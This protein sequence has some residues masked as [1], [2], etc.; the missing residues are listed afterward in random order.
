MGDFGVFL[1][2][3]RNSICI[4]HNERRGDP[5][6]GP[7]LLRRGHWVLHMW[8]ST[9]RSR[10]A[11]LALGGLQRQR[12]VWPHVHPWVCGLQWEG[13]RPALPD[14]PAQQRGRQSGEGPS[15]SSLL[16]EGLQVLTV[17]VSPCRPWLQ[18]CVRSASA[19]ACRALV[20]CGPAGCAC[21]ASARWETSSRTASMAL[22]ESFTPT[23]GATGP[24]TKPT[25]DTWSPKTRLTSPPHPWIW[26]ISRNH[27]ISAPT[28]E[29]LE[30]WEHLEGCATAPLQA[31]MDASCSAADAGLRRG[32]R[33]W[34]S[35][36]T[37][38][39][40]GAVTSAAWTAPAPERYT[41][42]YDDSRDV[43][44]FMRDAVARRT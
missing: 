5:R 38:P 1:R 36:A 2:L 18:R 30:L 20:P 21:P 9:Q 29:K 8:L 39:S 37:A 34:P 7:L 19:T 10:R 28:A 32:Q 35:G 16:L 11:G 3:P 43:S 42:V 23:R 31:W 25:R 44:V 17:F 12:G 27:Q 4:R 33:R 13:P 6:C 22:P 15:S 24:L 26:S 41:S 14:Q 40:T